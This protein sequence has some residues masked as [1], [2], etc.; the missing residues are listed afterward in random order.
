[1]HSDVTVK[2]QN[3]DNLLCGHFFNYVT[4]IFVSCVEIRKQKHALFLYLISQI[5][6]LK[7]QSRFELHV[8]AE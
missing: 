5:Y 4:L 1:M 6:K 2:K 7:E 8:G 3:V